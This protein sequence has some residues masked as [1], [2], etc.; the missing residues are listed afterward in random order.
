MSTGFSCEFQLF[1]E[2]YINGTP[3][4]MLAETLE[5]HLPH[6]AACRQ[7]L[8]TTLISA[9]AP[10]WLQLLRQTN[11]TPSP[12]LPGT[13]S[14]QP[15]PARSPA[16]E[17]A[18][19]LTMPLRL[20]S[21]FRIV[22]QLGAGGMGGVWEAV[23]Q[24]LHRPIAIKVL[25]SSAALHE[26][27]RLLQEGAALG[28][29][30]HPGIVR[31][32]EVIL[33]GDQP[34]VVMELV[35]G[36]GLD[37]Y[38]RNRVI[39]ESEAAFL[40][41]RIAAAAAHAHENKVIHRDLKPSNILLS[42]VPSESNTVADGLHSQW[43]PMISDFGIARLLDESTITH[44]GQIL[45][46][47]AYM[48]PEQTA[49]QPSAITGAVDIYGIGAILYHLLTGRPPFVT[50]HSAATLALVRDAD[51]PAPRLLRPGLSQDLE[52]I[53]LKC[54]AKTPR[55]RYLSATALEAD[56]DAFLRG[57][58]VTARPL[59]LPLRLLKW[60]RRNRL[61]AAFL[62]AALALLAGIVVLSLLFAGE[63]HRLREVAEKETL[64][65]I[66]TTQKLERQL[67]AAVDGM[68][69]L[70]ELIGTPNMFRSPLSPEQMG[71]FHSNSLNVYRDY[72]EY[73]G[74]GAMTRQRDLS[75]A[76]RYYSLLL[77]TEPSSCRAEELQR[78]A[79]AFACM[80]P[81]QLNAPG[82]LEL[83]CRFLE[84]SARAASHRSDFSLAASLWLQVADL[85]AVESGTGDE[86]SPLQVVRMQNVAGMH[87]NAAN[88]FNRGKDATR[89]ADAAG[90]A[91][92]I[93]RAVL[94]AEPQSYI[95]HVRLLD[96]S[97]GHMSFLRQKGDLRTA[98]SVGQAALDLCAASGYPNSHLQSTADHLRATLAAALG[99]M[100]P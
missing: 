90:E 80:S 83:R 2:D 22:R 45:G 95:D 71:R 86:P 49:G 54:L 96:Y 100:A 31:I 4:E 12:A 1:I 47:P 85:L 81:E 74:R 99:T 40:C 9:P 72:I 61:S 16:P 48:A 11:Q 8:A 91:C 68:D 6:C 93:L 70:N 60:V 26:Q 59:G 76:V 5:S 44:A 53:C 94:A 20:P 24:V 57:H 27:Q 32:Y 82:M 89:A 10:D 62:T 35:R 69:Q 33:C 29:L 36:P 75:A 19:R 28:R 97:L 38:L 37:E 64:N 15:Q 7:L 3:D 46:T 88:E 21:R 73:F 13:A 18:L 58:P 55:D 42:P 63:Q 52:N 14:A 34:A 17:A 67:E 84:V 39:A 51:P 77:H 66:A 30:T 98:V 87:M 50:D 41:M 23:D 65:S 43:Q 78:I 56:L 25:K 79:N 92:R